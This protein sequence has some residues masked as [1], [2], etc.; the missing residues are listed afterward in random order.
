MTFVHIGLLG[1][2]AIAVVPVLLHLLTLHRLKTIE[3]STFR[4]LF[5]SYV[6]QRR[7]IRFLE[8]ILAALRTLFLLLLILAVARPILNSLPGLFSTG[9][10][11]ECLMM[12]D[13]SASMNA[14]AGGKTAI[15]RARSAA[16][17]VLDRLP[18][19]AR[20][21]LV[22]MTSRAELVVNRYSS[23]A[24]AIRSQIE[25]M[26][27]SPSRA[28][29]FA[30]LNDLFGARS[31]RQQPHTVY[32][33]T[34]CQ[35]TA[36]REVREQGLGHPLP[37]NS[38]FVVV[39]VGSRLPLANSA[40][41][42]DAPQES[43]VIVGLPVMLR[44]KVVNHSKTTTTKLTLSASIES[45][46]IGQATLDLEPN[47]V[48]SHE[49]VF[50]PRDVGAKAGRFEITSD[51][52]PDDDSF[53]FTLQVVPPIKVLVVNGMV[54]P[55]ATE[56]EAVFVRS[57]LL[58]RPDSAMAG[59][60]T[61][62]TDPLA[63]LSP[64]ADFVRSLDV[65]EIAEGAVQPAALND[66]SVVVLAN[67]GALNTQQFS[68][69]RD[70]VGAGGGLLVFPGDRVNHEQYTKLFFAAP[71]PQATGSAPAS[72]STGPRSV[73]AGPDEPLV[74]AVLDAPVGAVDRLDSID[75]FANI[76]FAHPVF[77]VFDD[78]AG[79]YL[80]TTQF[81]RHFKLT[82]PDGS[83]ATWPLAYFRSGGPAIVESRLGLGTALVS[84]FPAHS[85]WSNLP[86]KP[87]FVPLMLR[88]VSYVMRP[89]EIRSPSV[90]FPGAA[91]EFSLAS[92]WAPATARVADPAGTVSPLPFERAD[93]QLA[94]AYTRTADK[95]L[96]S[97][98][99][100][101]GPI[102]R[103]RRAAVAFAVNLSPDE[104][105]FEMISQE[106]L[107]SWLAGTDVSLV[108]ASAESELSVAELGREREIWRPLLALMFLIIAGE[109]LLSTL[110]GGKTGENLTVMQRIREL[111]PL[112]WIGRMTGAE[113]DTP[114]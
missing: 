15:D 104:S 51:A 37:R 14:R 112:R 25:G 3:L 54:S 103:S 91:A 26:A 11:A 84:A 71:S 47:Q 86:L 106:Q 114:D 76:A 87:E 55:D 67:T 97:V 100:S 63:D 82:V 83:G 23:D 85:R 52:F 38:R 2:A 72:R 45:E 5:D 58:A 42:G 19:E 81:Y 13:C 110:A 10:A 94:A 113:A 57:A 108:D 35:A 7:R 73:S 46:P 49:F 96:Y 105:D 93:G 36:W 95:G 29:V 44:A 27:A 66:A 21:T 40:V 92:T 60:S 28:N 22:R 41:V 43:R 111:S 65:Q 61:P 18:R 77:T 39:N 34:D 20:V 62:P 12:I 30:A 99:V 33:F 1:L 32:L 88:M 98:D 8:A 17:A 74:D 24:D 90:V 79:R 107:A 56:G 78:P 80:A 9:G 64:S 70:F 109:F 101:G 16:I 31:E 68:W 102:E 59:G 53:L 48:A 69:L 50:V 75:R 6:Q 89:P 4:F